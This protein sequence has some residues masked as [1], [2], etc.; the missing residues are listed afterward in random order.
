MLQQVKTEDDSLAIWTSLVRMR[1][2]AAAARAATTEAFERHVA[3]ADLAV[4]AGAMA[5][6]QKVDGVFPSDVDLAAVL[7]R[8]AS[9]TDL[10]NHKIA[11]KSL[12]MTPPGWHNGAHLVHA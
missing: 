8:G 2:F 10:V 1:A 4:I 7:A 11:W 5:A 6:L 3:I 12:R 9:M